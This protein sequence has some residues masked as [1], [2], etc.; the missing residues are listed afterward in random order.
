MQAWQSLLI[1]VH[2][3]SQGPR[4]AKGLR[5]DVPVLGSHK[6]QQISITTLYKLLILQDPTFILLS[7]RRHLDECGTSCQDVATQTWII[8]N[9]YIS[10]IYK[11]ISVDLKPCSNQLRACL[12]FFFSFFFMR[13]L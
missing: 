3:C 1:L 13:Y 7:H 5:F 6:E 4:T 9:S 10:L 11:V 8:I 12:L 2:V